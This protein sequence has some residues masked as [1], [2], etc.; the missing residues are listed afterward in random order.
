MRTLLL[1]SFVATLIFLSAGCLTVEQKVY[2]ITL[3][4]DLSGHA[5]ITF[6]DIR[7]ESDDTVD[8]TEEDFRQLIEFYLEGDQIERDNPGF[9]NV[10][11]RLFEEDGVLKGELSFDFDSLAVVRLF[12]YDRSSPLMYFAG[13][14]LSSEQLVETNGTR[15]PD[16]LPVVFWDHDAEEVI[17]RTRVVSEVSYHRSL[18][19]RYSAWRAARPGENR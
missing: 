19:A 17:I 3:R 8:I 13:S 9:R 16:W 4:P 14:P 5:T 12:R 7:S 10:S 15:G 18:L 2:R 6:V 1:T 11:K